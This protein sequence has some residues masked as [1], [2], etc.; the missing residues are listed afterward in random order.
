MSSELGFSIFV[1]V[2][3]VLAFVILPWWR[4]R[5]SERTGRITMATIVSLHS[6]GAYEEYQPVMQ[7]DLDVD[8]PDGTQ[9]RCSIRKTLQPGMSMNPGDRCTVVIDPKNADRVYLAD[10]TALK[11]QG[12]SAAALRLAQS[13]PSQFSGKLAVGDV[14]GFTSAG[15][16]LTSVQVDVVNIGH[17]P[18]P[19]FCQQRFSGAI[20]FGIG[21]RVFLKLDS[22][23]PPRAGYILPPEF[24]K[25]QTIP[26]TG[27]RLDSLVLADELLFAGAKAT[28][29]VNVAE[30]Q[31]L[32][33][34]YTNAG[35][36]KWLLRL[37]IV[38]EDG[39]APHEGTTSI[40]VSNPEKAATISKIGASLPLRYD[41]NDP[42]TFTIDSIALGWGDPKLALDQAKKISARIHGRN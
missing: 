37:S 36:S 20:P 10:S 4:K 12:D 30:K 14:R 13:I 18:Q 38:P 9:R 31:S 2:A 16:G 24:T 6:T 27:N 41:P 21:D 17:P 23:T 33:D 22:L 42:P 25:G 29:T 39:S 32:P 11:R 26:R 1:A 40:A 8:Q 34:A 3:L 15:N 35:A 19:V 7:I 28:G 5:R